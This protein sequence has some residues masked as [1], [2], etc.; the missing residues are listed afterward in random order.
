MEIYI[1]IS[2]GIVTVLRVISKKVKDLEQN[3]H[4]E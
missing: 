1:L 2:A 4:M 3:G